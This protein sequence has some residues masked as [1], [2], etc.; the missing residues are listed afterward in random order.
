MRIAKYAPL[1]MTIV[2]RRNYNNASP[3]EQSWA[4]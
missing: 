3:I 1:K 4:R 2:Q